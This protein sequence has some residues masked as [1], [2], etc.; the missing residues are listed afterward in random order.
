MKMKISTIRQ[1][2][3]HGCGEIVRE[4]DRG[5]GR[6]PVPSRLPTPPII[7]SLPMATPLQ[8]GQSLRW[9]H[10]LLPPSLHTPRLPV[11]LEELCCQPL[12]PKLADLPVLVLEFFR[13]Q[14]SSLLPSPKIHRGQAPWP[15]PPV[16]CSTR[17]T[18]APR[19]AN[20]DAMAHSCGGISTVSMPN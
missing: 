13:I 7:D 19:L 12:S 16:N 4:K 5:H 2:N 18:T 1:T 9:C 17:Y 8:T 11:L 20:A 6:L 10:S 14:L 15:L 3:P